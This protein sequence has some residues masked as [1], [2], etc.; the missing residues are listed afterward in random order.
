MREFELFGVTFSTYWTMLLVATVAIIV[1]SA[2]RAKNAGYGK[3]RAMVLSLLLILFGCIGA[4][5]L[6]ILENPA[7]K[8]SISG[9]MSFFGSVYFIPFAYFLIA[10][11]F[12][13]KFGK[14]LDFVGIYVPLVL[15]FMRIGCFM[16]DCCGALPI[17]VF[18]VTFTPPVQ[19]VECF[20]DILIFAYLF[21]R[22][23]KGNITETGLQ[24]PI[25]MVSYGVLRMIMEIFRDSVKNMWGLSRGQWLSVLTFLVGVMIILII[26]HRAKNIQNFSERGKDNEEV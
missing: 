3:I 20:F 23:K 2:V 19:L 26:K 21:Y 1:H 6:F 8:F 5:L 10:P 18:G 16:N 22:E 13:T 14:C 11:L 7:S 25:F 15:A 24:Y 9:G 17:T 4:K 12:K